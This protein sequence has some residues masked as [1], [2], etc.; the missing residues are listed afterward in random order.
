MVEGA[1][2]T[3]LDS[4]ALAFARAQY[5]QKHPQHTPEIDGWDE[6]TFLNK[7]KLSVGGRITRAGV[8]LL[9]KP[10]STHLLAP[11]QA[12]ITWVLRD[13]Q[14]QEK[15]YQHFD[16]PFLLVGDKLLQK[17]RNLNVRHL[18]SGTL[19][20]QEVTQYDPWVMRETL[21]NCIAHQDYTLGGRINVV[22]SPDT[23]LFTNLGS[24]IPGS[25]EEM[26]RSDAPPE[27]YRNHFLAQAMVNL[28]MID[29]IGSGIKRMFTRQR[30]RSF[31]MPDYELDDPK[32]VVVRLTG[33]VLDEN[34]TRMLLSRTDLD[35]MD[36]IALD[37]VQKKRLIDDYAFNR[38][39]ARKLIEGRR[40]NLFV[41]A[42]V[43]TATG[44]KAAYIKNR[45]FDKEHYRGMVVSYL[46]KFAEATRADLEA[47][48]V[49]K[50]S[51]VL[52]EKQKRDF[53]NNLLQ[54]MKREG[55]IEA[56]GATRWA[57]WRLR[58]GG[59]KS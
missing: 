41:S 24:F 42:K 59:G 39:K 28:N 35:L 46:E 49:D 21:H 38:L 37:K 52:T 25:V 45:A 3:D 8:L 12:R 51:A 55:L 43:A 31:P 1:S 6:V 36:V 5:R 2:S 18:P 44:E 54:G 19:F 13:A 32:K 16:P 10:E 53:V 14:K 22:E 57:R 15:D 40:P 7:A 20:P 30:E 56:D 58:K 17:I 29:T 50:L 48:L 34:Y 33:Q 23:L 11:A 47:L 9:G 4:D 26:I 27:V